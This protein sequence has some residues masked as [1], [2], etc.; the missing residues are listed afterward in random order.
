MSA[1]KI[2]YVN[3]DYR[4]WRQFAVKVNGQS[5]MVESKPGVLAHGSVD[6]AS[7]L[8]AQHVHASAGDVVVLMN[9]GN[10][11][12]GA[13][14]SRAGTAARIILSDRNVLAAEA[15]RRTLDASDA[16]NAEVIVGQ[17]AFGLPTD[18]VADVVAIRI[19]H[20]KPALAHLVRDAFSILKTG[21]QCYI[22]GATNEGA[23]SAAKMMEEIFGNART[24]ATDGGHRVVLSIKN[25]AGFLPYEHVDFHE[26]VVE[27][28][29]A[30]H[31]FF[32]RPGVFSWNSLDEATGL[33]AE[34]MD[35]RASDRVLDLGCGYGVLGTIAGG[36]AREH[37]ITMLDV[38]SEA[39]RSAARS[40]QAAGLA[41]A[42]VMG[43]DIAAAVLHEQFD[44][45]IT[46]P[47]FH[48]GK[49]T[50]L[51]VPIQFIYDA[52]KVLAPGGRLNLVAN[53]TLPYETAIKYLFKN[54]T[55]VH[56]GKRFKVLSAIK[57]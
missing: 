7:F 1:T 19:P 8:L 13:A 41:N 35:I 45:V 48:V 42:R 12:V 44:V 37:P 46:N 3:D 9:G 51:S 11:L 47:P 30:R 40:A 28:N 17:G 39:V 15:T 53:R 6:H 14:L 33:L 55:S 38:D 43:S 57:Q 21:G 24:L 31:T 22:A 49:S 29:S 5:L 36:I 26:L 4:N 20:E 27:L 2:G 10:G 50:D 23:K 16:R 34:H 52:W 25:S 18:V 32:T 54:I 56:N